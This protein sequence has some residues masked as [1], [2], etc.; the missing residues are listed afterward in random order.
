MTGNFDE[1]SEQIYGMWGLQ[2]LTMER[3]RILRTPFEVEVDDNGKV[4]RSEYSADQR[5]VLNYLN[6]RISELR[7]NDEA[8]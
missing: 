1:V 2:S 3:N 7:N 8:A 4:A 6:E 5:A